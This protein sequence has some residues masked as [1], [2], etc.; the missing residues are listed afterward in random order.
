[1][2]KISFIISLFVLVHPI[3]VQQ[4]GILDSQE[5]M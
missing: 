2:P 4:K 3:L 1:M 5:S